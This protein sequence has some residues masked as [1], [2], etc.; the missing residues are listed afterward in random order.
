VR[1]A[2]GQDAASELAAAGA[3]GWEAVGVAAPDASGATWLLERPP[4]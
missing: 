3:D 2:A 4:A 1:V